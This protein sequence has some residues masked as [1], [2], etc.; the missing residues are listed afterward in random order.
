MS[1]TISHKLFSSNIISKPFSGWWAGLYI[2]LYG[3]VT[4]VALIRGMDLFL[5]VGVAGL[6]AIGVYCISPRLWLYSVLLS[7]YFFYTKG[8][9]AGDE[10]SSQPIIFALAYHASLAIWMFNH[11]LLK[12][13]KL[14]SHWADLILYIFLLFTALNGYIALSNGVEFLTW[15]KGWQLFL[16][17]LYYF[18]IKELIT[19]KKSQ[20]VLLLVCAIVLVTQ[21]YSNISLYRTTL[22][23]FKFANQ[24]FYAGIRQG[25]I[26]FSVASLVSLSGV[27]YTRKLFW[28]I[29]L[30]CFHLFCFAVLMISLARASWVG[31]AVGVVFIAI[32]SKGKYRR[33]FLIGTTSIA[34]VVILV[35][36]IFFGKI[37]DIAIGVASARFSSSAGFATDPSYLSRIYE[38]ESLIKDIEQ[39]PIGGVGLQKEHSRYDAIIRRSSINT[40]AHN[41]YLGMIQKLGIPLALLYFLL[42]GGIV[43]QSI[44][45]SQRLKDP[46]YIFLAISSATGLISM[47]IINFVGSVFDLREGMFLLVILFS[48]SFLAD[49]ELKRQEALAKTK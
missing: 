16:I 33:N 17:I 38:N 13:K 22:S 44:R 39:Y 29:P 35:S 47:G 1:S 9:A 25:A 20:R 42:I 15:L 28:K 18:P 14:F 41:N 24:L 30:L 12:K 27:L 11:I 8:G 48:F 32:L 2:S 10:S 46:F 3:I 43:L 4:S 37:A 5:L 26:V 40:Y 34:T 36:T 31:Y 7:S 21:G 23:N 45:L 19:D 6:I 49:Q